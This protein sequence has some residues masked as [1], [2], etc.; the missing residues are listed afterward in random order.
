MV[1]SALEIDCSIDGYG[2]RARDFTFS[3]HSVLVGR[4]N[5]LVS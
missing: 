1:S 2:I 4:E 5:F 3:V